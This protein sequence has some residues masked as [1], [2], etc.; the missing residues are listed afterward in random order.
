MVIAPGGTSIKARAL[1][2]SDSSA[3]FV[4][5]KLAQSLRLKRSKQKVSVSGIGGC[6][7]DLA[8][9]SIANFKISSVSNI[10]T[11]TEISALLVPRVI[12]DLP[13]TP[14]PIHDNWSHLSGIRLADPQFNI[15]SR[16]DL[17]LGVEVFAKILLQGRR[18]GPVAI[19]TKF[20][21]VLCGKTGSL[22]CTS[23]ITV[24]HTLINMNDDAL[25]KFWELKEPPNPT[26][27]QLS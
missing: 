19:Q 21:W 8:I 16:I 12:R 23:A 18:E 3:S 24:C 4:S 17:L 22:T 11:S 6:C 10:N 9:K 25:H 26:H 14:V 27:G 7:P 20:G 5:K 2:D 13:V 15:P 1:L